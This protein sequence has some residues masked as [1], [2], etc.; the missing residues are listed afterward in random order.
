VGLREGEKN[1]FIN[2]SRGEYSFLFW[3]YYVLVWF[4]AFSLATIFE[5][6]QM[7]EKTS[8]SDVTKF[9]APVNVLLPFPVVST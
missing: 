5:R 8:I 7:T 6:L 3:Q 9:L 1:K 2:K 4:I